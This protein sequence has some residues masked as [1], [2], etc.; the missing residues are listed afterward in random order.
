MKQGIA[1][2]VPLTRQDRVDDDRVRRPFHQP[3]IVDV[4]PPSTRDQAELRVKDQND[5]GSEPEDWCRVTKQ[6]D[7]AGEMIHP[8]ALP[9]CRDDAERNAQTGSDQC[10]KRRQ[11]QCCREDSSQIAGNRVLGD[12][13]LPEVEM[14]DVSDIRG[15]LDVERLIQ[16]H[17]LIDALVSCLV[18]LIADHGNDRIGRHHPPDHEGDHQQPQQGRQDDGKGCCHFPQGGKRGFAAASP[19]LGCLCDTHFILLPVELLALGNRVPAGQPGRVSDI[20]L[21]LLANRLG[22][23]AQ[24]RGDQGRG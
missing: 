23:G 8:R 2:H 20:A 11:F 21:D 17:L 24:K 15:E 14:R 3:F 5:D 1:Q 7:D 9:D 16:P 13:R 12:V 4:K 6:P 22:V 19:Y 10:R 18:S